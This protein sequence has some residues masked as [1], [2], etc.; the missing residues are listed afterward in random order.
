MQN[1]L[2]FNNYLIK[3]TNK[4]RIL[5]EIRVKDFSLNLEKY[6]Q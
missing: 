2:I 3:I 6:I 4:F 5:S 1:N